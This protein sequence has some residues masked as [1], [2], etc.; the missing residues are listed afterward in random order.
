MTLYKNKYRSES[1]RL[2]GWDYSSAGAYFVTICTKNR[3]PYFGDIVDGIMVL[4][5][6][7]KTARK[8]WQEIFGHFNNIELDEFVI[9]PNHVHG[10]LIIENDNDIARTPNN[11]ETPKLGVSTTD[12]EN[13]IR[14]WKSGSI[15]VIVNQ[16]KR[17]CTITIRKTI[18]EFAWQSLFHDHII[19]D[20]N[21]LNGIREYIIHN[22]VNWEDDDNY[23]K[24]GKS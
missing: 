18:P 10:V 20:E 15:G 13:I 2:K 9:M 8:C 24:E 12:S 17:K 3:I 19:R 5:E 23:Q 6:P 1:T 11:V 16:F 14:A 21:E 4:S 22:P 7:G